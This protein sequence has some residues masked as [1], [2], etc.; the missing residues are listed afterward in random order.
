MNP[1]EF[2][3]ALA[4]NN[5][6]NT[7]VLATTVV[8]VGQ[9]IDVVSGG[10]SVQ[11]CICTFVSLAQPCRHCDA[12]LLLPQRLHSSNLWQTPALC[13]MTAPPRPW[14][15]VDRL[16]RRR[17]CHHAMNDEEKSCLYRCAAMFV[18]Y[19][20]AL[21]NDLLS[22][23]HCIL[24]MVPP[25]PT[26]NDIIDF[27]SRSRLSSSYYDNRLNYF[28]LLMIQE[29]RSSFLRWWFE[30]SSSDFLHA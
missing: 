23:V 24:T 1:L 3:R 29:S 8:R 11:A 30:L 26:T 16:R 13:V 9:Q 10:E 22:L 18:K 6:E 21:S 20:F 15:V 4:T 17:L 27:V 5:T 7:S 28:Q 12:H 2:W 25:F 19:W 14:E